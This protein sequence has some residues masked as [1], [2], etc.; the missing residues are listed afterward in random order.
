MCVTM[1]YTAQSPSWSKITLSDCRRAGWCR[2]GLKACCVTYGISWE[3]FKSEGVDESV[4]LAT[5]DHRAQELVD[6]V[7]AWAASQKK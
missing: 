6:K 3:Q 2:D 5:G 1:A 7:R 4:I